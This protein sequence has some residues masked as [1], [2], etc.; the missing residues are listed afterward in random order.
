MEANQKVKYNGATQYRNEIAQQNN[1]TQLMISL[2]FDELSKVVGT[3][4]VYPSSAPETTRI[5]FTAAPSV[6]GQPPKY[7]EGQKISVPKGLRY[8]EFFE[9]VADSMGCGKPEETLK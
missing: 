7:I 2:L 1:A 8:W 6:P 9:P 5:S 3:Y 4:W